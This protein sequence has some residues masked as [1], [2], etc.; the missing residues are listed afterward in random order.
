[1]I[2]MFVIR[3]N[4]KKTHAKPL[5]NYLQC[6]ENIRNATVLDCKGKKIIKSIDKETFELKFG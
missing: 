4:E 2:E 6:P 5:E 1:M 3:N